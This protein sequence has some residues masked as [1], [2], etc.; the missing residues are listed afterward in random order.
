MRNIVSAS[1][2]SADFCNLGRDIKAAEDMG[3]EYI[4]F[5]VMDGM[6]VKN[7]SYGLPV[8]KSVSGMTKSILDVHLMIND[9]IRYVKDFAVNGADIITFHVEAESDVKKT[10]EEIHSCGKK[11]G[12]AVKPDTPASELIPYLEEADMILVMTVEP[13]FGGQGFIGEMLDKIKELKS[14]LAEKGLEIPIEVDGGINSSTAE[15][16]KNAGAS[17]LVAG[18]YLFGAPDMKK[19]VEDLIR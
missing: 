10:I 3:C 2:L 19:A 6:F 15:L 13:G 18:S 5:D 17:I 8:L 4:H 16:V 11:A 9:P 7:I 1:I 14:I 12:L